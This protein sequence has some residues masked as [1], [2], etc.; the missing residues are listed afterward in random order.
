MAGARATFKYFW[1]E[2]SWEGRRIVPAFDLACVK[3]A[4]EDGEHTEHMWVG[5]V[6]FDGEWVSGP[7]INSPNELTNVREGDA[8]RTRLSDRF[9][10]WMLAGP[11]GVHGAFTIQ[12]MRATMSNRERRAHDE[13]W[14]LSFGDPQRVMLPPSDDDHPMAINMAPSLEEFLSKNPGAMNKA[15]ESGFTM[16]HREA[17][18]GNA[19]IVGILLMRGANHAARTREGKTPLALA[20][21]LGW[22]NVE[23]ALLAAGAAE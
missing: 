6:D 13:A 22:P 16:L 14:Q 8:V 17:L 4:F 18:A 5:D 10:D 12:A 21:A 23:K 19:N 1:R 15:D 3:V 20:R 7:L 11:N 9:C 2:L